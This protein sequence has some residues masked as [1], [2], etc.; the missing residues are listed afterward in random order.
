V[1]AK[2]VKFCG[3]SLDNPEGQG[4]SQLLSA[5]IKLLPQKKESLS[6]HVVNAKQLNPVGQSSL[7]PVGQG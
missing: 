3:Q 1:C 6:A 4:T 2:Q 7:L 5:S